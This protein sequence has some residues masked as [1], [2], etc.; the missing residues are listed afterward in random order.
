[1]EG[2]VNKILAEY[3]YSNGIRLSK[4]T[5]RNHIRV[6]LRYYDY[7]TVYS[8]VLGKRRK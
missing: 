4:R 2:L 8:I 1:M 3:A 7:D 6:M 5:L